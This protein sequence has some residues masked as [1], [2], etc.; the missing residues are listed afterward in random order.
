MD[1][2]IVPAGN[3]VHVPALPTCANSQ[4][5][6]IDLHPAVSFAMSIVAEE[7]EILN[8]ADN[9]GDDAV[10]PA[11]DDDIER[12]V[13]T[14]FSKT[15]LIE[16]YNPDSDKYRVDIANYDEICGYLSPGT[17][18]SSRQLVLDAVQS[19]SALHGWTAVLDSKFIRCNRYG[20]PRGSQCRK[21]NSSHG[22][23][24]MNCTFSIQLRQKDYKPI[25]NRP[26]RIKA[27][28]ACHG[29]GCHPG[30]VNRVVT[31]QRAGY[32][33]CNIPQNTIFTLCHH[34]ESSKILRSNMIRDMVCPHLPKQKTFTKHDAFTIRRRA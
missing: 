25:W 8:V 18:W 4:A 21:G 26:V 27:S 7:E 5:K 10:V 3:N 33:V 14:T 17:I 19:I 15:E 20:T 16:T 30:V 23:L 24:R 32:Y 29:G 12:A 2:S 6:Q 9:E 11:I 1:T 34:V 13:I 28:T 22:A 31:A